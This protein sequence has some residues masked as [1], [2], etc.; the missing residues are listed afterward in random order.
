[1]ATTT[2]RPRLVFPLAMWDGPSGVSLIQF[3]LRDP[4]TGVYFIGQAD[5]V[6][7]QGTKQNV[8]V[9]RTLPN[10]TYVDS[11]TAPRAGHGSSVGIEHDNGESFIVIGHDEKG[12]GRF[13]YIDGISSWQPF[14]V[15]PNGDVSLHRD[16]LVVRDGNEF[17]GFDYSSAKE[18]KLVQLFKWRIKAWGE[19]FQGHS[20]ISYGNGTGR[21]LV[22]RDVK[23]KGASLAVAFDFNGKEVDRLD[24]TKMGDE[25]EGF[26]IEVDAEGNVSAWIVKRTGGNNRNRVVVATY[27][28]GKMNSKP[29]VPIDLSKGINRVFV[30]LG[31]PAAVK[32]SSLVTARKNGNTSRYTFYAQSWLIALGYYKGAADG[33]WGKVTQAAF[34]NFR[35]NIKPKWPESDCVGPPG[36]TSLTLLRN[37]AVKKTGKDTLKVTP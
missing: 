35:R 16:V 2:A 13:S 15:L 4:I 12:V 5:D 21:V 22:H 28:F 36:I 20:V 33:R 23:T 6:P 31:K 29:T 26:L 34:D 17:T 9:R 1:M 3:L 14:K 11:R 19:R 10:L 32:L 8:V 37:A 30:L 27:W 7:G 24:T 18:G 25:A